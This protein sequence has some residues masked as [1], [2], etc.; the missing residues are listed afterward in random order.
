MQERQNLTAPDGLALVTHQ[1]LH[2]ASLGTAVWFTPHVGLLSCWPWVA[3]PS[4][5]VVVVLLVLA[6]H[7]LLFR[8]VMATAAQADAR[9]SALGRA[10]GERHTYPRR[11]TAIKPATFPSD[12]IGG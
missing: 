3:V 7:W 2:S 1:S 8:W 10:V 5:T 12:R 4:L 9:Y 6:G 11:P